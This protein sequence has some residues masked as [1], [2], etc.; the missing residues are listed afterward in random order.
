MVAIELDPAHQ[1][2]LDQLAESQGRDGANL[3]RQIVVD[4]LDLLALETDSPEGWAQAS[5]ALAP[6]IMADEN[7]S[8]A[9]HGSK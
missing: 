9:G 6:E 2:R 5:T 3:A 7:W 1:N 4:Y 8:D